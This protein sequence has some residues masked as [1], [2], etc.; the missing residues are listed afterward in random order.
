MCSTGECSAGS[1]APA[2][3]GSRAVILSI[4][5]RSCSA[6]LDSELDFSGGKSE[7]EKDRHLRYNVQYTAVVTPN[8][9]Q[10]AVLT[11]RAD[12]HA[13][14]RQAIALSNVTI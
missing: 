7:S 11:M 2:V 14:Q 6:I 10:A 12:P 1:E 3:A 5:T 8:P 9:D 4:A 13:L